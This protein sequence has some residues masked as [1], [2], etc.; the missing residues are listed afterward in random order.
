MTNKSPSTNP[1]D[2][3]A[4]LIA[5][6]RSEFEAFND[7]VPT[8]RAIDGTA[9]SYERTLLKMVGVPALTKADALAALDLILEEPGDADNFVLSLVTTVRAY[10][11]ATPEARAS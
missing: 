7:E 6:F 4:G 9:W 10:I 11:E 2:T 1:T 5:R 8:D 3:L